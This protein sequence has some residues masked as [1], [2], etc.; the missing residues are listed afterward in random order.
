MSKTGSLIRRRFAAILLISLMPMAAW[1]ESGKAG[2]TAF[3]KSLI[4]PG[5]GQ[6]SL[7]RTNAAL[8]FLGT[9][10]ALVGGML[11]LHAYGVS[12]RDDYRALAAAH[13][14][15]VGGHGHDFY[16][17]VGNWMSVDD[18]NARRLQERDF[19][20]M[21]TDPADRW[22]W[23]SDAQRAAMETKRIKSDR[24]FNSML[25]LVGGVVLNHVASA[26]H[27]GRMS[28]RLRESGSA[29]ASAGWR[30]HVQPLARDTGMIV[31]FT[32]SF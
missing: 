26:I 6:Y 4:V 5:W 15:V 14:G 22:Y 8:A 9:E 17:D 2:G 20:A 28:A 3:L 7:G 19:A 31:S 23:S 24:A 21:Y 30:M 18:Y 10:A 25:Y 11:A 16:V 13:A 27:A 29:L 12:T 1:A 32:R